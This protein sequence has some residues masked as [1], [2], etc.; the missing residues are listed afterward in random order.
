MGR[1]RRSKVGQHPHGAL[2]QWTQQSGVQLFAESRDKEVRLGRVKRSGG[3]R[4]CRVGPAG[5]DPPSVTECGQA[6]ACPD[7]LASALLR[8]EHTSLIRA[9]RP[10][11]LVG[12]A[13][14]LRDSAGISPDFAGANHRRLCADGKP[15]GRRRGKPSQECRTVGLMGWRL[16]EVDGPW[17]PRDRRL[18]SG[19]GKDFEHMAVGLAR[20][21]SHPD[22]AGPV[23]RDV[24]RGLG[25]ADL[26]GF[27]TGG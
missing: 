21:T 26:V 23:A 16:R 24:C 27:A 15:Y 11:S 8:R 17:S 9:R 12:R 6:S 7:R 10:D 3:S 22:L 4:W 19:F 20:R 13:L 14:P 1:D 18:A 25:S 2:V 5:H